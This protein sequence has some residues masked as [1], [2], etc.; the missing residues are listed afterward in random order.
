MFKE[1][2]PLKKEFFL[3]FRILLALPFLFL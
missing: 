1:L 3:S 2:E